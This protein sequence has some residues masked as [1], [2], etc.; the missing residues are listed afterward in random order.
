MTGKT[1]DLKLTVMGE[2]YQEYCHLALRF[3]MGRHWQDCYERLE[4][5]VYFGLECRPAN[6]ADDG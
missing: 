1:E 5:F 3:G 2:R 6:S 4:N